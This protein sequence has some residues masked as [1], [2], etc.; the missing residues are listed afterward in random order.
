MCVRCTPYISI[1]WKWPILNLH[2]EVQED[3][4]MAYEAVQVQK[5]SVDSHTFIFRR[6]WSHGKLQVAILCD[7]MMW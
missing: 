3:V 2:S 7:N 5:K 1:L 4:N 6:W